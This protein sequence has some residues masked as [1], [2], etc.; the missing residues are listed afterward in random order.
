[1]AQGRVHVPRDRSAPTTPRPAR[2]SGASTRRRTTRRAARASGIWSTPAVDDGA[3]AALRRQR[4]RLR[5]ADRRRSPTRSSRSTTRPASSS[6]RGSSPIPTCS[7]PATPTGKDAD[8][9]ASP[10]L[11]TSNGR[12]LVGAGDK[13]GRLPRARPR[14]RQGR[15][16]D[17]ADAGQRRSAGRSARPRSSTAAR[18]S[19]SNVGDPAT[20]APTNVA[21]V[22]ALDPA[23][24]AILWT[25]EQF[26]GHDLRP[27]RRGAGRR[28]RRHRPGHARR[29]RHPDRRTSCGRTRRRTRRRADRRSWTAA[30]CGATGS[31]CSGRRATGGVISFTVGAREPWRRPSARRRRRRRVAAR[32]RPRACVLAAPVRT[33]R[34][35]TPRPAPTTTAAVRGAA[36]GPSAGCDAA[37]T[38]APGSRIRRIDVGRRRA[39]VTS[40]TSRPRYDG[41]TAVP[42]VLGLHALTVE[43]PVRPRHGRLRATCRRSTTSSAS[44]RRAGSTA[45]RRTGS[46]PPTADNYDVAFI[47]RSARPARERRCAST[48]A[49][50]FS[51]GMSNGAQMSS[52]L[53]CRLPQ[54][55]HGRSRR[56]SGVEFLEPVPGAPVPVIAFHGTAD[57]IVTYD[58]G[59]LNATTIAEQQLLEGPDPGGAAR[60]PL[61]IDAAMRLWARAQRLRSRPVEERVRARG[62]QANLAGLRRSHGAVHRRRRRPRVARQA[63]SRSSK[64]RSVTPRPRST[65]AR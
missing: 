63:G 51:T 11:W 46:P 39:D 44:R 13:G 9:G 60:A 29:A 2:R 33:T 28:V 31:R 12:D 53:A 59:G 40:S 7:A 58:G 34:R 32:R 3:R 56:S 25:A 36:S 15:V 19:S 5:R 38:V 18:S 35:P 64:R 14:H 41:T 1:M 43:L 54:T 26:A 4:Q 61:G 16:G 20:N 27:R 50:V 23:T 37:A 55:D 45:P 22:F 49:R 52:L 30:C 48:R 42:I 8:V 10:N 62:A 21:K 24:G 17:E 6:G 47:G 57:P 65:R